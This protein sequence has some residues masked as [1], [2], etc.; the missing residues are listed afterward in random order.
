MT[1][2]GSVSDNYLGDQLPI[3]EFYIMNT[4][5]KR[6]M[7]GD[8]VVDPLRSTLSKKDQDIKIEKRLM[9][10][11]ITLAHEPDRAHSKEEILDKAWQG[12]FVTDDALAVAISNL[13][14]ALGCNAKHPEYIE[15]ISGYGFKL[16]KPVQQLSASPDQLQSRFSFLRARWFLPFTAISS[17]AFIVI[18]TV[19]LAQAKQDWTSEDILNSELFA[20]SRFLV[21]RG[22]LNDLE[23]AEVLLTKLNDRFPEN[24]IIL[25]E[26]G[27]ATLSQKHYKDK[28]EKPILIEKAKQIFQRALRSDPDSADAHHQLASIAFLHDFDLKKSQQHFIQSIALRPNEIDAHLQY[29][30]LLLAMRNFDQ[31]LHHNKI[32]QALDPHYYS[33][34]MIEWIYNMSGRYE[35]AEKEL[36]KLYT[37]KPD[38]AT[39]RMA[40]MRLYENMGDEK[41][42]FDLY[43]ASFKH[44]RYSRQEIADAKVAFDE[45]GLKRLNYWLANVKKERK[46]IG[47][48]EPPLSTARYH[49]AAGEIEEAVNHLEEVFKLRDARILWINVDPKYQPLESSER[50]Q[51]LLIKLGLK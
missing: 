16:I 18:F 12:R 29:A 37:V 42:A 28:T 3:T 6:F 25:C 49:A 8:W 43:L 1:A 10:V 4:H 45:G 36:G 31:A 40:A 7:L 5:H 22:G 38:S 35:S 14:K 50:F 44:A 26:L 48:Y 51:S 15:T 11:L 34:E 9:R 32:A 30:T 24:P 13:R 33:S 47:Q 21:H 19:W 39:Y 23:Q 46:D 2:A 17:V 20:K 27:K 41:R